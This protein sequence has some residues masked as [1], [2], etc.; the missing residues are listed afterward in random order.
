MLRRFGAEGLLI[1][2]A[3]AWAA[4]GTHVVLAGDAVTSRFA[5]LWSLTHDGTWYIDRPANQAPNP[6]E[7]NTVDKVRVYGRTLSSKPPVLT[8]I[9]TGEY[10]A[11]HRVFGWGLET[12]ADLKRVIRTMNLTVVVGSF[13][14]ALLFFAGTVRFFVE[15]PGVRCFL[16]GACA[17]GTQLGGYASQMNNHV[18]GTAALLVALY[19]GIGMAMRR[20]PPSPWRFAGFGFAAALTFTLDMP[21]T[22]FPA[23][24]G[25]YLLYLYP[26]WTLVYGGLGAMLPLLVHFGVMIAIT[27]SPRPVQTKYDTF[28]YEN[29]PWRNPQG[30][31]A[32]NLPKGTY[33]FHMLFGRHG[34]FLLYPV[35]LLGVWAALRSVIGGDAEKRGWLLGGALGVLGLTAYYAHGTWNYGGE[36][37]GFRWY[38]GAMPVL[39]LM[40]APWLERI[41]GKLCGIVAAF[42]LAVSCYSAWECAQT[43][44][45]ANQ[46]WTARYLFG[47][48]LY[49]QD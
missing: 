20:L 38:I 21:L 5:T 28:L 43:P 1:V 48:D 32:L 42:L 16:L 34:A 18:P 37:Y 40:A 23:L 29:S 3:V 2:V 30:I 49:P 46:E 14:L 22:I 24:L 17:F 44:W 33:L 39:L 8:L 10:V 25:L 6:F 4:W 47:P 36:A 45:T 11:L 9:L 19:F 35:L 15:R 27:G 7:V 12:K 41:R 26:R 13:A 31:D